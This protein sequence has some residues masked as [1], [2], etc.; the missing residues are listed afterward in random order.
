MKFLLTGPDQGKTK[1]VGGFAFTEGATEVADTGVEMASNILSRFHACYPEHMLELN[2]EGKLVLKPE[3]SEVTVV[4]VDP[5]TNAPLA[6]ETD[7]GSG[8]DEVGGVP[9]DGKGQKPGK[10]GKK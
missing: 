2:E 3:A 8:L 9:D 10:K 6:D 7:D 5:V 4:H 1:M